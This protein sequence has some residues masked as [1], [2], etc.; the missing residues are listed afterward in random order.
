MIDR[1]EEAAVAASGSVTGALQRLGSSSCSDQ[2]RCRSVAEDQKQQLQRLGALQERHRGQEA[3]VA[4]SGSVA[5]A[6]SSSCSVRERCRS[7]AEARKQQLQRP[8]A[9]QE[10][11][12][13]REAAVAASR[14]WEGGKAGFGKGRVR[15]P[16]QVAACRWGPAPCYVD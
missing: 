6:G 9:L 4:A 8:G 11:C 16:A 13:G 15:E 7:V 3:A 10:R 1:G 2:E 12:R 5:E 14:S